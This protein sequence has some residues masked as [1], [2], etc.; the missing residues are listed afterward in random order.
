MKLERRF[1]H[2]LTFLASYTRS[3]LIDDASS[4]FDATVLTGPVANFPVADSYNRDLERDASNGDI[5][6]V[7]VGSIVWQVPIGSGRRVQPRGLPGVLLRDWDLAAIVTLQSGTPLAVSQATNFNAFAGFG[8]QRPNRVADPTLP[9]SERSTN[10]WLNAEAFET[11][12]QFTLGNSSRNPVR[13][14]GYRNVDLALTRRF[15]L[16]RDL[17]IEVRVEAFNLTNT[18]SLGAPN[19]VL[20]TPGFGSIT[21]AGDPRVLQLAAK[22]TF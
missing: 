10:R 6:N 9:A 14:P 4:V 15:D 17:G 13:G 3:K 1:T 19:T 22:V 20:G 11:A 16:S 18:P 12:P 8:T 7:F 21:S 5:P 2:G